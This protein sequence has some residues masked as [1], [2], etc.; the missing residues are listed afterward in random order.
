M[1]KA[2]NDIQRARKVTGMTQDQ[3]ARLIGRSKPY[4]TARERNPLEMNL[5]E[6]QMLYRACSDCGRSLMDDYL[7]DLRA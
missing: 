7:D 4:Y 3:A 2:M 6:F 5:G 1:R